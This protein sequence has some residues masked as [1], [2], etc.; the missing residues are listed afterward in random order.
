MRDKTKNLY[1]PNRFSRLR[2][3]LPKRVEFIALLLI[4][5]VAY[6]ALMLFAIS[7]LSFVVVNAAP[8][9]FFYGGDLNPNMTA[10][11]IERLKAV[12]GL[13][14]GL[15]ERYFSWLKAILRLDFGISFVNGKPVGDEIVN[16][17]GVTM[18]ISLTSMALTFA[19]SL[20]LG[21]KAGLS[22]GKFFDR[23]CKQAALISYA[24]PSFYLAL[25]L[26]MVFSVWLGW[27]PIAGL[28]SAQ[29]KSGV[30]RYADMAWH[31]ALPIAVVVLGGFGSLT[32]YIRALTVEIAK[33][34]YVFY[35][36]A[37]GLKQSVIIRRYII[38]NLYPPIVTILGLSLPGVIGGSVIL[39]SVFSIN[40]TGL[41]FYQSALSRDYPTIMGVLII[42][43]FLTLLGN[44]IADLV[45]LK[46]NPYYRAGIANGR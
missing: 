11:N 20:W 44:I 1:D 3:F 34:D 18:T 5:K 26:V 21:I 2:T 19:F 23:F 27:F 36:Q 32:L 25:L 42:G 35:A 41:L 33:S 7:V 45:L 38:P 28:E 14:K 40:G 6:V 46:L 10:E 12:Y 13:D 43:A 31:L 4:K 16:R 22:G 39:E 15:S 24:F 37:R 8:N 30:W 17:L 29:A 9:N